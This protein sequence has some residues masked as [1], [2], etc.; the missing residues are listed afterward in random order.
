[1][2]TEQTKD[3]VIIKMKKTLHE[4]IEAP[5]KEN[6]P[7][8][9]CFRSQILYF[10]FVNHSGKPDIARYRQIYKSN[11]SFQKIKKLKGAI[12]LLI[13]VEFQEEEDRGSTGYRMV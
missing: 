8:A 13:S 9:L 6:D 2:G 5:I 4:A 7:T 11:K 10:Y 1:M 12:N 3:K